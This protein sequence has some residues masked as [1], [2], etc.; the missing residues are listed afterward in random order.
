MMLER[1]TWLLALVLLAGCSRAPAPAQPIALGSHVNASG[2]VEPDGE[3][4]LIIPQLTGRVERV[5]VDEGDMVKTGQLLAELENA[6][7]RASLAAAQAQ[8]A[9]QRAE[10]ERL[11]NGARPEEFRAIRAQRDEAAALERQAQSSLS[12]RQHVADRGLVSKELLDEARTVAATATAQ[13]ERADAELGL[14]LAGARSEDLDI[15]EAALAAAAAQEQRAQA[16]LEK[17][18]IRAPIDGIVLKRVLNAGETVTALS[19]EPLAAIGNMEQL[20]VRAEIDE[21]DIARVQVGAM[22]TVH[23]DAFPGQQFT[24]QLVR[25]ARRMGTRS[26]LSDDPTQRRAAKTLEALIELDP[27]AP[28]PVG[29]RV[30]V[31]I[32]VGSGRRSEPGQDNASPTTRPAD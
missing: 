11:R 5:L 24:G 18:R 23:S 2:V 14:L 6:E 22:A 21:L 8:V 27:G 7:Q 13:R 26:I 9:L 30:D 19:P 4:R 16:E 10:L 1:T 25:L 20:R 29:L 3:E 15:A 31:R 17:T 12:R 28:L 32:D